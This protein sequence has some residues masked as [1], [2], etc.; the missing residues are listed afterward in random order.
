MILPSDLSKLF[1]VMTETA[2][3]RSSLV[4]YIT[5]EHEAQ[6][7]I[8][9]YGII[10]LLVAILLVLFNGLIL[11]PRQT[12]PN[13]EVTHKIKLTAVLDSSHILSYFKVLT[14]YA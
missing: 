5:K 11:N 13:P 9:T 3:R 4:S 7:M 2:R 10:I 14:R 6:N 1:L 12:I 8:Q